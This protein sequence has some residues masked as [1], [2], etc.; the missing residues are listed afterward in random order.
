MKTTVQDS[1][2]TLK[3]RRRQSKPEIEEVPALLGQAGK[4][5]FLMKSIHSSKLAFI[6]SLSGSRKKW[7]VG[8]KEF[9]R[10]VHRLVFRERQNILIALRDRLCP[11]AF[12]LE[13][14][15]G[16]AFSLYK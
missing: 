16:A 5:L 2:E 15:L 11:Q 1:L 9:K 3:T 8:L 12:D 10:D 6:P 13:L 4:A 14:G 7:P